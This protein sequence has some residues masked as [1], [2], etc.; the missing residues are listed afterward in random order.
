MMKLFD[1]MKNEPVSDGELEF[2]DAET[3][4]LKF[5]ILNREKGGSVV[6]PFFNEHLATW[7]RIR[8]SFAMLAPS[9]LVSLLVH[10]SLSTLAKYKRSLT[11]QC[12]LD[13][14]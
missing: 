10:P 2:S 6:S 13:R 1:R 4:I 14:W 5:E 11:T 3:Y 8:V 7:T 9:L 12:L